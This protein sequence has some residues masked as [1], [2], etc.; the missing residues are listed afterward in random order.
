MNDDVGFRLEKLAVLLRTYRVY[1]KNRGKTSS[2][3]R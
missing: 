3:G 2:K 1:V